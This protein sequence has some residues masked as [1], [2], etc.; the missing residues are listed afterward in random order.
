MFSIFEIIVL[1]FIGIAIAGILYVLFRFFTFIA[2]KIIENFFEID[3]YN[4]WWCK[5]KKN[6]IYFILIA[7]VCGVVGISLCYFIGKYAID[8]LVVL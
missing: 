7:L 1:C 6:N 5:N 3:I 4:L 8:I 2:S